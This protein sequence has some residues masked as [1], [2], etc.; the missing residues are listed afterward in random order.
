MESMTSDAPPPRRGRRTVLIV[1][2][3]AVSAIAV[4]VTMFIVITATVNHFI[5]RETSR[6]PVAKPP[7]SLRLQPVLDV[8]PPPCTGTDLLNTAG[9]TCFRLAEGTTVRQAM[10][11]EA[12]VDSDTGQWLIQVTLSPADAAAF[13]ELTSRLAVE[14]PPRNQLAVLIDGKIISAPVVEEP[15]PGGEVH[16][17]GGLT[18]ESATTLAQRLNGE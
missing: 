6:E 9:T 15:I 13:S 11:A 10:R 3:A 16:I 7:A 2:V 12:G 1:V 5:P 4:V 14:P 17:S 8:K 18:R